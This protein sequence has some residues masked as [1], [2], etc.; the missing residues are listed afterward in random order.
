VERVSHVAINKSLSP[1]RAALNLAF[2][3]G[4]LAERAPY[5]W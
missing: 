1:L 3:E 5:G 2:K 4:L